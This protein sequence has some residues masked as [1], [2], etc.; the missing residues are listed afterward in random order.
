MA[1]IK[2]LGKIPLLEVKTK[3]EIKVMII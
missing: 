2:A 3:K 1:R